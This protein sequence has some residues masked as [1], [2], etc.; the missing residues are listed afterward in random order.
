MDRAVVPYLP[1]VTRVISQIWE[2]ARILSMSPQAIFIATGLV[3]I[4]IIELNRFQ[5]HLNLENRDSTHTFEKVRGN[6]RGSQFHIK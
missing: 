3:G 4:G 5:G 2:A 1:A 6:L